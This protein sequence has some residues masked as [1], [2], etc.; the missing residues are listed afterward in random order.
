MGK[1]GRDSPVMP[2]AM[3]ERSRWSAS[4]PGYPQAAPKLHDNAHTRLRLVEPEPEPAASD[5]RPSVRERVRAHRVV[6]LVVALCALGLVPS[7]V[8]TFIPHHGAT[9]ERPSAPDPRYA[10]Q[11]DSKARTRAVH[12]EA[13]RDEEVDSA[14]EAC[15]GIGLGALASKYGLPPDPRQVA[16]RYARGYERALHDR[17]AQGC[18]NGL[19]EGG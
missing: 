14:V 18:L 2:I 4:S 5:R 15:G 1:G 10:S 19:L 7:V 16:R 3:R 13:R 8:W 6:A 12:V 17:V 11:G 9:G